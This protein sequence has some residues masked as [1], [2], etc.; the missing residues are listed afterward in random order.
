MEEKGLQQILTKLDNLNDEVRSVKDI[1]IRMEHDQ[2]QKLNALFDGYTAN[3]EV[4][5]RYDPRISKLERAVEKLE[6][7]IKFLSASK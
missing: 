5:E 6:L 1:V 2:G 3:F 7:Q 4:M